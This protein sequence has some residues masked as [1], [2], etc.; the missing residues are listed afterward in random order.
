MN[1]VLGKR[2][3]SIDSQGN[4]TFSNAISDGKWVGEI[5]LIKEDGS[6]VC[7]LCRNKIKNGL[8]EDHVPPKCMGNK[9]KFHYVNY[10]N[11]CTQ[12]KIDYYGIFN[13]G[14]KYKTIC[15]KCNNEVLHPYDVE[16]DNFVKDYTSKIICKN[17]IVEIECKPQSLIKG[18]IGHFLAASLSN[19]PSEFEM[20][21]LAYFWDNHQFSG[22]INIY[23]LHYNDKN[24]VS[25]L[26][27]VMFA[28]LGFKGV[29]M[30]INCLKCFPFA[31]FHV[32]NGK[33]NETT[34]WNPWLYTGE[35]RVVQID[36]SKSIGKWF[37]ELYYPANTGR[38]LGHNSIHS[39]IGFREKE[40]IPSTVQVDND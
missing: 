13:G 10:L 20:Q 12:N 26:R 6:D 3:T 9:G 15:E 24:V 34:S 25:V 14:I 23:F 31:F 16:M 11:F 36:T 18:L 17:P 28:P 40:E 39:V 19:S 33:I 32:I 22:D 21:M 37:P 29:P 38:I 27:E 8:S 1:K 35:K 7:N 2:I 5:Q 4:P 30:T